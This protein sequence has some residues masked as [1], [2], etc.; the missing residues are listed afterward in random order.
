[1]TISIPT[2]ARVSRLVESGQTSI[3]YEGKKDYLDK[4]VW[5]YSKENRPIQVRSWQES[6]V[7]G[8]YLGSVWSLVSGLWS[9]SGDKWPQSKNI[10]SI[11][12]THQ[13]N[14]H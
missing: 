14:E 12:Y 4:V 3:L 8:L 5:E 10:L 11:L 2:Q 1:M 7:S 6:L 13:L 9:L